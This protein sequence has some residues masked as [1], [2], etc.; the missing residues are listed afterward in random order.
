MTSPDDGTLKRTPFYE[1]HVALG[2]RMVP[3]AGW[4]MPVQYAG[5]KAEHLAVRTGVGLFDVSHM[6]EL[7][8]EGPGAEAFLNRVGTND[9]R[10]LQVGQAQYSVALLPSG[11][12]VDDLLIYKRAEGRYLVCINASRIDE[13]FAWFTA[14]HD[15]DDCTVVNASA[16]YAQ[17]AIQGRH[18]AAVVGQLTPLDLDTIEYYRFAE[19]SIAGVPGLVARTGYT[20]EDGFELFFHKDHADA[21]W[22]AV[23]KA[24]APH[25]LQPIGLGARDTLRLEMKYCLY[26]NDITHETTPLEA[27]LGWV[28]KL[29]KGDFVGRD[30]LV[31]QQDSGVQRFLT[32]FEVTGRGIARQGYPV[33]VDGESFGAVTSGTLTPSVGKSIGLCYLPRGKARPGTEFEVEIRGKRVAAVATKTP[34][35]Q[36]DY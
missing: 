18:A 23:Q 14:Q 27:R 10:A 8:V 24:G 33:F 2:A 5:L 31:A 16:D 26:G 20:G 36:R 21:V 32:G 3:F 22:A 12:I 17:L 7:L 34:F 1:Q 35:Y 9:V 30:A 19:D 29:D 28:V 13:D 11:G 15:G 4:S 6:G 25:D